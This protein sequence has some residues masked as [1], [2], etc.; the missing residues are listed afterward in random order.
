MC[1]VYPNKGRTYQCLS[2]FFHRRQ[3][4][5]PLD[6]PTLL[7]LAGLTKSQLSLVSGPR[8]LSHPVS[9]GT[10]A[11]NLWSSKRT[12][13]K[14]KCQGLTEQKNYFTSCSWHNAGRL[15]WRLVPRH[16]PHPKFT[17]EWVRALDLQLVRRSYQVENYG[18][19]NEPYCS[20]SNASGIEHHLTAASHFAAPLG[21]SLGRNTSEF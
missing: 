21:S 16:C 15:Q 10:A 7:I 3:R 2:T 1:R 17:D 18:W 9:R 11:F 20:L 19:T 14:L 4:A 12:C 8:L 6:T 5:Y 13:D